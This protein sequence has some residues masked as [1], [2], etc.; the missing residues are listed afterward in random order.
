MDQVK[1]RL[2]ELLHCGIKTDGDSKW[3]QFLKFQQIDY[4]KAADILLMSK[5]FQEQGGVEGII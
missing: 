5:C 1:R 3:G 4:S 2:V